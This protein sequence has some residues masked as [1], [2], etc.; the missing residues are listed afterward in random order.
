MLQSCRYPGPSGWEWG[1]NSEV[2]PLVVL[3]F[4]NQ[5]CSSFS[6]SAVV[7]QC[8][9]FLSILVIVVLCNVALSSKCLEQLLLRQFIIVFCRTHY[10]IL[11]LLLVLVICGIVQCCIVF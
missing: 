3:V 6:V 1:R 5:V 9:D 2:L 7:Y 11:V 4:V 10:G 8:F